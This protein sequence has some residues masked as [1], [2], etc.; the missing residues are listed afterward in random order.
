[1]ADEKECRD[2]W[3]KT[4]CPALL[5]NKPWS[6]SGPGWDQGMKVIAL[7]DVVSVSLAFLS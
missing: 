6:V 1:M 5:D 2:T 4:I 7:M 3:R